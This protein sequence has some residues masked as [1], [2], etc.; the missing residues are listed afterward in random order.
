MYPR[1]RNVEGAGLGDQLV[2][3]PHVVPSA[4]AN[5]D[6]SWDIAAQIQEGVELDGVSLV[7]WNGAQ[8]KTARQRSMVVESRA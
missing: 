3:H 7:R 4:V 6:E 2:E 1:S 8:G 5:M